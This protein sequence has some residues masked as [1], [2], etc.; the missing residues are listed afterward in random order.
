MYEKDGA[1][2]Y[3]FMPSYSVKKVSTSMDKVEE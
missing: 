1:R 2:Y 3:D